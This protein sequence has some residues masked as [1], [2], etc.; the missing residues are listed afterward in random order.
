MLNVRFLFWLIKVPISIQNWNYF[1]INL[2]NEYISVWN[3]QITHAEQFHTTYV[4][5][6]PL[7]RQNRTLHSSSVGCQVVYA[8]WAWT[9]VHE[10]CMNKVQRV[11]FQLINL[12]NS[13]SDIKNDVILIS[14]TPDIKWCRM[15]LYSVIFLQKR[16]TH[17]PT[18]IM[19][20]TSDK[21]PIKR[22]SAKFLTSS[23]QSCQGQKC[24]VWLFVTGKRN[25]RRHDK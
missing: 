9:R 10:Q 19:R 16:D 20:K 11:L 7:R 14:C 25:L 13:I 1:F 23:L 12:T 22:H 15:A 5:S 2:I 21:T 17:I 24:K 3:R 4:D 6:Q 18:L 8:P